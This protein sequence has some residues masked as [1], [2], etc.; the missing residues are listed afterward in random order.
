MAH[1]RRTSKPELDSDSESATDA[2]TASRQFPGKT[3]IAESIAATIPR[4]SLIEKSRSCSAS[5]MAR[6]AI[7][8]VFI[9]A[10]L[11]LLAG[12][13]VS[14]IGTFSTTCTGPNCGCPPFFSATGHHYTGKAK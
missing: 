14:G 4:L 9:L 11:V 12:G 3:M 7:G 2:G 10:N 5:R 6:D 13:A 8:V 1:A